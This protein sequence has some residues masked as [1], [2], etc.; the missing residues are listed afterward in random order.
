MRW[1]KG[2]AMKPDDVAMAAKG[3]AAIVHAVNPPGYRNWGGL[4]LPMLANT[5]A[6]AG[7]EGATVVLPGTVYNYREDAFPVLGEGSTQNPSTRKGRIRVEMERS[8][9]AF[10]ARGGRAVIVRAGDF[11][12]P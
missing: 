9:R 8:L 6:A 4:V 2:D 1:L 3:C 5:I 10:T 7:R 11:F 12:G